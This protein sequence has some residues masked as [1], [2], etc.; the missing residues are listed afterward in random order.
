MLY[1]NPTVADYNAMFPPH[2]IAAAIAAGWP[3]DFHVKKIKSLKRLLQKDDKIVWYLRLYRIALALFVSPSEQRRAI[4]AFR[5]KSGY[6]LQI[7]FSPRPGIGGDVGS[8]FEGTVN[9]DLQMLHYMMLHIPAIDDYVFGWLSPRLLF[10]EL[11]A[12]E[13]IWRKRFG[14][15]IPVSESSDYDVITDFGDGFVWFNTGMLQVSDQSYA[16]TG[17]CSTCSRS[18]EKALVLREKVIVDNVEY[19]RPV[20]QFCWDTE[21]KMLGEMKGQAN[22]KPSKKYHKYIIPLL[23]DVPW[24]EGIIGG[25]YMPESN[26]SILDLPK[27]WHSEAASKKPLLFTINEYVKAFGVDKRVL[28]RIVFDNIVDLTDSTLSLEEGSA[29]DFT[30]KY[31]DHVTKWALNVISGKEILDVYYRP[32]KQDILYLIE[33]LPKVLQE[34]WLAAREELGDD[35]AFAIAYAAWHDGEVNGIETAIY[36]ALHDLFTNSFPLSLQISSESDNV[37]I[38][39]DGWF[40]EDFDSERICLCCNLEDVIREAVNADLDFCD[41]VLACDIDPSFRLAVAEPYNGFTGWNQKAMEERL[42]ELLENLS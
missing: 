7:E 42:T 36:D 28:Y 27:R 8:I 25:G 37:D 13:D 9:I 22:A 6:S 33:D 20:L 4:D 1:R 38:I 14:A 30:T 39:V 3:K 10:T 35:E 21:T 23:F 32:T 16:H 29:E 40:D 34:R 2:Y 41:G 12:I 5:A 19:W 11:S 15:L 18:T 17:H 26:F 24:I 31:G